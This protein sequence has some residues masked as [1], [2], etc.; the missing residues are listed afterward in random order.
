MLKRQRPMTR[1]LAG[2]VNRRQALQGLGVALAAPILVSC[3]GDDGSIA[4]GEAS[5]SG[6]GGGGGG[7]S[8]STVSSAASGT[9]S[10]GASSSSTGGV[11]LDPSIFDDVATCTLTGTDIEGPFYIDEDEIPDDI[12]LVRS[13]IR[14]ELPGCEFTFY[15]RLLDA[16]KE[17]APIPDAEIYIWHCN[18]DGYY[19]GFDGQDPGKPYMGAAE[20]TPENLDRYCR[21]VQITNKDGIVAFTTLYP[22]WYAGRPIHVHLV[23]RIKGITKRLITTQLYF[24]ADFS[25]EVHQSEPAYIARAAN[26]P[27]A[28]LNPPPGNPVIPTMKHSPGLVVGTLNVIVNGA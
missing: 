19:S 24:P 13:D 18:A 21:G 5:S 15:F 22:G 17:C 27:A 9:S 25:K 8:G 4:P 26:I 6:A 23:A 28:S 16:K 11:D 3:G 14:G 20:R 12:S 2:V 1:R 10:S 7:G